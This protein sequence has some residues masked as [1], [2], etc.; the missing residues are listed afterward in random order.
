MGRAVEQ[1][2]SVDVVH[3]AAARLLIERGGGMGALLRHHSPVPHAVAEAE[4]ARKSA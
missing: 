1:A 2:A 3:G 4:A